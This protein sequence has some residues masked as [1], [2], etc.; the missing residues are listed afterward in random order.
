MSASDSS[1]FAVRKLVRVALFYVVASGVGYLLYRYVPG[2]ADAFSG[3]RLQELG[4]ANVFGPDAPPAVGVPL[5]TAPGGA[6]L[7]GA[8]SMLGALAI[9][10]PVTW[11]YMLTRHRRGY[12]E[13][14]V[15]TLLI[16]PVAV[17]GI[18]MI[19][20]N[21][22]ALAFSL[23]GIVAAVRFRTTLDDTK[24]AVYVFLAIGVGLA[25]GVQA[26]G[27]AAVLSLIFNGVI[28]TL[29][30]TRF[31][32]VYAD[33]GTGPGGL[34]LGD[35]LAGPASGLTAKYVGDAAVLDAAAPTDLLEVTD[36]AVR[37]ERHISEERGKKKGKRANA[38]ILV[39]GPVAAP[40]QTAAET[41]L[42]ELAT[43]WKLAEILASPDG[44]VILQYL[45]RL[46][47]PG[48]EGGVLDRL[49]EAAPDVRG[50][51]LRSLK[52]LKRRS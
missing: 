35:A 51:E 48:V 43:R 15:H 3:G 34:A 13:S 20:Q 4:D 5:A 11:V 36:R 41:V 50:A 6:A 25:C 9:M 1:S 22:L 26:V 30:Y 45:A 29:W 17:T 39:H 12:E 27:L 38:L 44:G 32:N 49:R 23:A 37:M 8:A 16:L 31:G 47:G 33:M 42:G 14:V 7:L 18:V 2:V 40:A 28:V 21:S 19:V 10:I 52:G 46:D 24:D